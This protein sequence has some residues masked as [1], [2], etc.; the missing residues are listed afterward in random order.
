MARL[1]FQ[2]FF[3][4]F[5]KERE[6]FDAAVKALPGILKKRLEADKKELEDAAMVLANN[7]K[8][9]RAEILSHKDTSKSELTT[10]SKNLEK[11]LNKAISEMRALIQTALNEQTHG[12]NFIYDKVRSIK[13]GK[14]ADET[15]IV[16]KVLPL[17]PVV[18][19]NTEEIEQLKADI[20]ELKK[21]PIARSGGGTSAMGV[22][23]AFKY[24]AHTEAPTGDIDGVNTTYRV[25]NTIFWVAGFTINGEQVA[26]LPNFTVSGRTITFATA[27]PAAYN[28]KD[29][30]VKYIGH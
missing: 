28:G 29:F 23:Q 26:E 4:T 10:N 8:E 1:K 5:E 13:D 16:Q 3:D 20:E 22:A 12:M 21:R 19:D 2:E 9:L 6:D 18:K 14:D 15:V 30:E 11:A 24:I 27:I 25:K 7:F 17:I